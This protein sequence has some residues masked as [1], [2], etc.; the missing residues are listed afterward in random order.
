MPEWLLKVHVTPR[1]SRNQVV[2][3][4][5]DALCI[6]TTAPPV[7]GAANDAVSKFL[8]KSLGVRASQVSIVSGEKSREKVFRIAGLSESE[9]RA[10]FS[11]GR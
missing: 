7:E 9:V 2:G 3:W 1:S 10:R 4:R 8:A 11:P 5:A 6:K